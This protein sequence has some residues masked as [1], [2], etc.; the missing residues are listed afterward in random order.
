MNTQVLR[1]SVSA[2]DAAEADRYAGELRQRILDS[3]PPGTKVTRVRGDSEAMQFGETI[4]VDIAAAVI[5]HAVVEGVK[6]FQNLR[7][8]PIRVD[9]GGKPLIVDQV[10]PELAA[11]ITKTL[12][13]GSQQS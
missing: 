1:L 7:K 6:L 2:N 5:V 4:V 10:T 9:V 11:T 12:Q 8:V 3:A 13:Q